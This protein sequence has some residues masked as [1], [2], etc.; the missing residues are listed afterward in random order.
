[1]KLQYSLSCSPVTLHS[2]ICILLHHHYN[3][4][5]IILLKCS[6]DVECKPIYAVSYGRLL[7]L[8]MYVH[9]LHTVAHNFTTVLI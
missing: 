7:S 8:S 2:E 1:M 5:E 6:S 9:H 4:T 3:K